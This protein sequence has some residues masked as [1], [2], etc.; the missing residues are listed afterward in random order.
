MLGGLEALGPVLDDFGLKNGQEIIQNRLKIDRSG[1][2][3]A[4]G[5]HLSVRSA[6]KTALEP[7]F[8]EFF[9]LG[10]KNRFK[11]NQKSTRKL[12]SLRRS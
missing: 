5:V 2:Q 9:D 8:T 12:T 3:T 6:S 7:N 10:F 1:I 11:I 4:F